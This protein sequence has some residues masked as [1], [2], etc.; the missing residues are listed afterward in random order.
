MEKDKMIE[1]ALDRITSE[2]DDVEGHSAMEHSLEEC[3]DPLNCDQ[4]GLEAG[5]NLTPDGGGP[6]VKIEVHKLGMPSLDGAKEKEEGKSEEGLSE[7]EAEQLRK[8]LK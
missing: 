8:L 3:P 2:L 7:D 1:A 6:S 5:K 4:H